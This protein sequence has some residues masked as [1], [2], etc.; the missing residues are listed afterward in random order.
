VSTWPN[1]VTLAGIVLDVDDGT[2]FRVVESLVGW[3]DA[4]GVRSGMVARAGQ[5]G[6]WDATGNFSER[7]VEIVGFV[8]EPTMVAARAVARQLSALRPQSVHTFVV[9]ESAAPASALS[10]RVR[11]TVGVKP[12]WV[13]DMSFGFTL[14]VT[15][16]DMLRY[17]AVTFGSASLSAASGGAGLTY[18]LVYPRD[19]GVAAGVTPGAVTVSN[20]GTAQFWPV[21]RIDGPVTNPV[22]TASTGSW[23]RYT[24]SLLAGQWLDIDLGARTV[25]LNGQ[26]SH[27]FKVTGGGDWLAVPVGGAT[28][29]FDADTADPAALLSVYGFEGAFV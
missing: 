1:T 16:P 7:V 23:L 28:F 15:A 21:L 27:R 8:Q 26:V 2:S 9:A 29:E 11:V 25:L 17:G 3:D 24:G 18:P 14:Q 6:A 22:V 12:V 4:P 5:D 10:A 19:Y 20:T 13:D